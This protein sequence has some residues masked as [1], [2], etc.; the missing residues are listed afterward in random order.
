M[1]S[2]FFFLL[3]QL[4]F[5]GIAAQC[6]NIEKVSFDSKDSTDGYYLAIKPLSQRVKGVLVLL[7]S[8]TSPES[9]LPETKLHNVAYVNDILTIVSSAK[10]KLY[11]DSSA[12]IRIDTI[13]KDVV[14]RFSADTSSFVLAGYDE[15][16]NIALRYTE[17]TYE[18]TSKFIIQPK[19]VLCIDSPVDLFGLWHWAER[20]IK[21]NYWQGSVGDAR[22]YLDTMTKEYG[23]IYTNP[24]EYKK[25]SAFYKDGDS[26]G[27]EQYLKNVAVRLYYDTDIEWQLKNR[28]NSYYDTKMPDGS[29]LIK[30][31]LLLGNN[32]AEFIASKK[33]GVRS[34][35]LRHPNALSIVDEAECIQWIKKSLKIF[36]PN[37]WVAPY[38]FAIPTN[39]GVEHF[40]LPPDFA[41]NMTYNGVEDIRFATGWGDSTKEDYWS[42][43]YLWWINRNA[44]INAINLQ[45]NLKEY[46]SGLVGRNIKSRRIPAD[47]IM[48]TNVKVSK[49]KTHANDLETYAGSISML[50]YMTLKPMNLQV[51]I[52]LK[53]CPN[54][55]YKPV[56]I[57]VSPQLYKHQIWQQFSK[58]N[59]SFHCN[60]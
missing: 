34:N 54:K 37:T 12:I 26:I 17:L 21:K 27:N 36:D 60:E 2:K 13:L 58:I 7:T 18:H 51:L 44:S 30:R 40:A 57:G 50:D 39:W 33:P 22:Y 41:P 16:G 45:V 47:K 42:Y 9:L 48:Q 10:Q 24:G 11:A 6:Q 29:E 31:L 28:R 56:I 38:V 53:E 55:E 52:H 20:Q 8:F 1:T 5:I 25:L 46:Y 23:T 49:I 4:I 19:A 15:A 14:A 59:S 35:G 32:R 43:T 3:L